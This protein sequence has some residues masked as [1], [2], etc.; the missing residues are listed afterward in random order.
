MRSMF[1]TS[2]MSKKDNLPSAGTDVQNTIFRNGFIQKDC[3]NGDQA[4]PLRNSTAIDSKVVGASFEIN[5]KVESNCNRKPTVTLEGIILVAICT[6]VALGFCVPI[7]IYVADTDHSK[8]ATIEFKFT[9][10]CTD[11]ARQVSETEMHRIVLVM[12]YTNRCLPAG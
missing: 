12:C 9:S 6:L 10:N 2:V 1:I 8:T 5:D 3:L 4:T 7:L 11:N